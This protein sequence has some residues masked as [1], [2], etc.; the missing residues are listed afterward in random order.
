MAF[1]IFKNWYFRLIIKNLTK[2]NIL[3]T[4]ALKNYGNFA[5]HN[6]E[7]YVFLVVGLDHSCLWPREGLF[8]K[9]LSLASDFFRILGL[10]FVGCVLDSTSGKDTLVRLRTCKPDLD[11][12]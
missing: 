3:K 2:C 11:T 5:D 7:K 12:K 1:I 6:L 10:G 8:S 9:S 4:F